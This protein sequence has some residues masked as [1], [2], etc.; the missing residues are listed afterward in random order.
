MSRTVVLG[1]NADSTEHAELVSH[2]LGVTHISMPGLLRESISAGTVIGQEV[3]RIQASAE[4]VPTAVATAVL[5]E[6]LRRADVADG[7]VLEG[8]P[9]T[10][11]QAEA[12]DELLSAQATELDQ[13]VILNSASEH[14]ESV[15]ALYERRGLLVRLDARP[16][17]AD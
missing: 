5:S 11:A 8:Y 14:V 6:R 13:V 12:L 2:A 17:E 10:A 1:S 16:H 15:G 3:A 4:A 7:F 9:Q